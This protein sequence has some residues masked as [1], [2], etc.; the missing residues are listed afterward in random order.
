MTYY[1]D[2][3]AAFFERYFTGWVR[4]YSPRLADC[5]GG[6][7]D[8]GAGTVLDLCCGTGITAEVFCKAG[9][10][11]VGVDR[12]EGMLAISRQKLGSYIDSGALTLITADARDFS[13]PGAVDAAICLDGALNHLDSTAEL[14]ACFSRVSACLVDGGQFVF[15]VFETPHLRHW[16]N[17]TLTDEPEAMIAKRGVWDTE[18]R[19]GMLRISGVIDQ[20]GTLLRIDQTLRSRHY[21]RDEIA[22]ALTASGLELADHDIEPSYT[23]CESG[24]CSRSSVPCRTIYRAVKV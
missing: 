5:L 7:T 21:D 6:T 1:T 22:A 2:E 20:G 3:F 13:L 19:Y 4:T 15:D 17:V 18:N 23:K 8:S 14:E 9:W 16:N 11:V 12:S 10:D 24:S